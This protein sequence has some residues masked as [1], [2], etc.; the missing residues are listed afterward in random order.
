M[1]WRLGGV[2]A[3]DEFVLLAVV[4]R[5]MLFLFESTPLLQLMPGNPSPASSRGIGVAVGSTETTDRTGKTRSMASG[6]RAEYLAAEVGDGGVSAAPEKMLTW[7]CLGI[8]P[9]LCGRGVVLLR[10][11]D[12]F[13]AGRRTLSKE[14]LD[15]VCGAP[16]LIGESR[17]SLG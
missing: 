4:S 8:I 5:R 12:P 16:G 9:M 1:L 11:G 10:D 2:R 6:L 13:E 14:D 7:L 15:G 17:R 3:V